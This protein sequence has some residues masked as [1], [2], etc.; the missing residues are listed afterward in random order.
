MGLVRIEME[1]SRDR[2]PR[3][4]V[5]FLVD[6]GVMTGSDE[7]NLGAAQR[8]TREETVALWTRDAACVSCGDDIGTLAP[9][10]HAD[11]VIVDRD[12]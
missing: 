10:N 3:R 9:G 12:R 6:S 7:P 5:E 11:V 4:A 8:V 2:G 1:I